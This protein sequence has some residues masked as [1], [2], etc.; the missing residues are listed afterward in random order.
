MNEH[1]SRINKEGLWT[2]QERFY[3]DAFAQCQD[4][5][6]GVLRLHSARRLDDGVL[7]LQAKT[8]TE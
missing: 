5:V 3:P 1:L 8:E 2:G 4:V 6:A 7:S